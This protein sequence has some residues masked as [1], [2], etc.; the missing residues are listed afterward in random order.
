MTKSARGRRGWLAAARDVG[1][2]GATL[3]TG[4]VGGYGTAGV[5]L[6]LGLVV[7]GLVVAVLALGTG[8]LFAALGAACASTL[9]AG[10]RTMAR[11]VL[12]VAV[13]ETTAGLAGLLLAGRSFGLLPPSRSPTTVLIGLL[14]TIGVASLAAGRIREPRGR[15]RRLLAL[16]AGLAAFAAAAVVV[17]VVATCF[18]RRVRR[19]M[20]GPGGRSAPGG[21]AVASSR[22]QLM[23]EF[24]AWSRIGHGPE[25]RPPRPPRRRARRTEETRHHPVAGSAGRAAR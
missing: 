2:A 21:P 23:R 17:A 10:D 20:V 7:P 22:R 5:V 25:P 3:A 13:A 16:S 12:V 8:A 14:A 1:A 6:T 19:V 18:R 9:L 4:V 24:E 11:L 15:L